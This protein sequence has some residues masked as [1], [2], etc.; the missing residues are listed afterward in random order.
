MM[1][2]LFEI[3]PTNSFLALY[4]QS[5]G[6]VYGAPKGTGHLAHVTYLGEGAE[7]VE[8]ASGIENFE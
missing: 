3:D 5:P 4:T 7:S 8:Q 1:R 2:K 6:V